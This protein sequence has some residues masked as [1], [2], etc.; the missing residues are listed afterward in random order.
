MRR[1]TRSLC[2]FVTAAALLL[3]I[4]S[5]QAQASTKADREA[6]EQ[7]RRE[8]AAAARL[9]ASSRVMAELLIQ[10][11]LARKERLAREE[12]DVHQAAAGR[13]PAEAGR[14]TVND[15][16]AASADGS[17]DEVFGRDEDLSPTRGSQ[18][19]FYLPEPVPIPVATPPVQGSAAGV[20]AQDDGAPAPTR[21]AGGV[22]PAVQAPAAAAAPAAQ[23][24]LELFHSGYS[25]YSQGD[26]TAA[27]Q[28]F[29]S[30]LAAN[31]GHELADSAQYWLGQCAAA[32]GNFDQA[33]MEYRRVV[34][35]FPFGD[36]VPDA[37]LKI[38][39]V[40]LELGQ[41]EEARRTWQKLARD[42]PDSGAG[43]RAA[44]RLGQQADVAAA[45][46]L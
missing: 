46:T 12:R 24:N 4:V 15:P 17:L 14:G 21:G 1:T 43:R 29:A 40:L 6:A 33:L 22:P 31:P 8:D 30:F 13:L 39:D 44:E 38:G 41:E 9:R 3:P 18:E 27:R 23:A 19:R 10:E 28:A 37:L 25:H 42:F 2:L 32:E 5:M 11:E 45:D 34:E 35:S 20:T 16:S 7:K 26:Y 36:K